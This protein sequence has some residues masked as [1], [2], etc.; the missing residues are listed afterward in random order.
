MQVVSGK[1][2]GAILAS[3][4]VGRTRWFAGGALL[5]VFKAGPRSDC[6]VR[7]ALAIRRGLLVQRDHPLRKP[8]RRVRAAAVWEAF[9]ER[10]EYVESGTG[11]CAERFKV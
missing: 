5:C 11:F 1:C 2:H 9:R 6:V 3:A 10:R 7:N 4:S 8:E